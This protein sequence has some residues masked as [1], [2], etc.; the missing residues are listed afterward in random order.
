VRVRRAA[1][2]ASVAGAAALAFV[3][4]VPAARAATG[5]AGT[6]APRQTQ[7]SERE[8]YKA[9]F[10]GHPAPDFT[11][12]DLHGQDVRLS[13][14]RGKVVLV[15]FWYSSCGPCRLETPGLIE[16]HRQRAKQGLEILG[17]NLD[18]ILTPGTQHVPLKAFL[19]EFQVPYK[20]LLA[21]D[22][23]FDLYGGIPV[24]PISFL[25]DRKGTVANVFWGAY[26]GR[27]IDKEIA[28]YLAA[29]AAK[30]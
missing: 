22:R 14:L 25:V 3:A 1:G 4:F 24:Q 20:V 9:R 16:L 5:T 11:L 18:D 13:A 6:P 23:V 12:R 26:P 15:N 27:V 21:T 29:P 28:P 2:L 8:R 17:V 30:P 7:G 10:V 19:E